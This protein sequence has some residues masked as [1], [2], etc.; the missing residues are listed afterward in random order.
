[1]QTIRGPRFAAEVPAGW[2]IERPPRTVAAASPDGPEAVSVGTFR[3]G[4][5]FRPELWD[6]AVEELNDV[7]ARRAERVAS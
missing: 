5:R 3:L 4:K 7:A 6:D 2:R 1:M